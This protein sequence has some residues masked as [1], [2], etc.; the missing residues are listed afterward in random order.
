MVFSIV[1]DGPVL[2]CGE[3]ER[4][5]AAVSPARILPAEKR[6]RESLWS[7]LTDDEP[8]TTRDSPR[9]L[10]ME[11]SHEDQRSRGGFAEW[12]AL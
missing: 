3:A 8:A 6:S 11:A 7:S 12:M 9:M 5:R 10:V 2:G 4:P 1:A